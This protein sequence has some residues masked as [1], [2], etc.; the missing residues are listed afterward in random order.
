[1]KKEVLALGE[2]EGI[3]NIRVLHKNCLDVLQR[4]YKKLIA[5][6][7]NEG[8]EEESLKIVVFKKSK[9]LSGLVIQLL[10]RG[11][12]ISKAEKKRLNEFDSE[13]YKTLAVYTSNTFDQAIEF[14]LKS[15]VNPKV[16]WSGKTKKEAWKHYKTMKK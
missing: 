6:T 12:A 13:G 1:M 16:K 2:E 14:Y 3:E 8:E 9:G 11:R 10:P 4:R 7:L 15:E 5:Y